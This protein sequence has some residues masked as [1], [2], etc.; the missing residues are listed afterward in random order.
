MV[1][2]RVE[3]GVIPKTFISA[4]EFLIDST[5]LARRVYDSGFRPTFLVALWRGGTFPGMVIQEFLAYKGIKTDH[6]AIRTQRYNNGRI[7]EESDGPIKVYGLDYLVDHVNASDRILVVDDVWDK[8]KTIAAVVD[9]YR[10]LARL[11]AAREIKVATVDFK[12]LRNLTDRQPDFYVNRV[13]D[14]RVYPH[15]LC[16]LT[17]GEIRAGKHPEIAR[18][19]L[20]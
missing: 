11:N 20:D 2:E 8:G 10:T 13:D 1:A 15:E 16:G 12:P 17:L 4:D 3:E 9:Q 5:R 18:L 14:W 7:D 6:I 19:L